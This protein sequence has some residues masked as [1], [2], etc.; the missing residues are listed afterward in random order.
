MGP[1]QS[2]WSQAYPSKQNEM[3]LPAV[4][5]RFLNTQMVEW[6]CFEVTQS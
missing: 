3:A 2:L 5:I 6:Q 4:Y 1:H